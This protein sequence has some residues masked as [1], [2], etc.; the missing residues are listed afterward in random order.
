MVNNVHSMAAHL[1][2][3]LQGCPDLGSTRAWLA[4]MNSCPLGG[5]FGKSR[6]VLKYQM[7]FARL[8]M[9]AQS[10]TAINPGMGQIYVRSRWGP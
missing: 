5:I 4:R 6:A 9:C 7:I 3:Q 8:Q 10:V 1:L 2:P